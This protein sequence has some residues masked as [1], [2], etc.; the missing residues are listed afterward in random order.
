MSHQRTFR[1]APSPN[2]RLHLGHAYSA[3][4]T[5][6]AAQAVGGQVLLRME[7][8]DR[9]RCKPEF[10]AAI[11]EDLTWLGLVWHG[12]VLR[13]SGRFHLYRGAAKALDDQDLL[14]PCFCS[15]TQIAA[16]ATGEDPDGAPLYPGT[17]RHIKREESLARI[18]AGEVVQ[19]RLDMGKAVALVGI[20]S[21]REKGAAVTADPA[22]WGDAVIVR[23]DTP[24]SYHLSVVIDDAEQGVTD[25][26]RGMDLFA[27]T[28]LHVLLQSLL[29]LP[30]PDYA[31][32]SLI[33]DGGAEKLAKS[34]GSKS[35]AD[36]RAEGWTPENVRRR[37][38]FG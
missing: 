4:T 37:L 15:R 17:C 31:H 12:P 2:G 16:L 9:A 19:W 26:T 18:A 35:L 27:A 30:V 21:F 33:T 5:W 11:I 23:K 29:S 36:L 8:I 6:A 20:L 34:R 22:R 38:G 10:D 24:T 13:Q 1:F 25:V 32:H 7:D 3:L 28:D 14:Y